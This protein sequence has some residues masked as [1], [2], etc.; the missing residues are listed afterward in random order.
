MLIPT[1]PSA[2]SKVIVDAGCCEDIVHALVNSRLDYCNSLL[3][4]V[5]DDLLMKL[6]T[7]QSVL[8][9]AAHVVTGTR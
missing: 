9:A 8:N 7:V 6:L 1:T 5:R 3:Y 2:D 4:K